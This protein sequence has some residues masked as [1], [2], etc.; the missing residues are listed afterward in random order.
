MHYG[1]EFYDWER[2]DNDIGEMGV[3]SLL[4]YLAVKDFGLESHSE[5]LLR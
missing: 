3:L 4:R 5:L 1:R 2:H